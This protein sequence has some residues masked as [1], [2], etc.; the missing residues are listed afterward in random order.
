MRDGQGT[1]PNAQAFVK[2]IEQTRTVTTVREPA[3]QAMPTTPVVLVEGRSDAV[4]VAQLLAWRDLSEVEVVVMNGITNIE[5]HLSLLDVEDWST[6]CG[7]CDA[8]EIRFVERALA[9]RGFDARGREALARLGFFVCDADLEDEL[10]RALGTDEVLAAID[11]LAELGR[12]RTLQGQPEWRGRPLEEQLRRFVGTASGR[13]QRLA[14]ALGARLTPATTP[15]PLRDLVDHV[16][17]L[18]TR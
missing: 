15:Q 6:V 14:Q 16:G 8:G 1:G 3:A 4:V 11:D 13:K 18:L 17:R 7:L 5:R 10:F 12:L 9:R 2:Q